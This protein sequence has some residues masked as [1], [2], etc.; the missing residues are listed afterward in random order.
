MI[1]SERE[2]ANFNIVR[3]FCEELNKEILL[4]VYDNGV[5]TEIL[6]DLF[7]SES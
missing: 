7:N 3:Q 5:P 4:G 1:E 2:L 6:V